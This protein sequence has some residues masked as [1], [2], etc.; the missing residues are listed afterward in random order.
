MK[1]ERNILLSK[2]VT[3][4][5]LNIALLSGIAPVNAQESGEE[6]AE[7]AD[8]VSVRYREESIQDIPA[9]VSVFDRERMDKTGVLNLVDMS[10]YLPNTTF[11]LA[12]GSNATLISFMRGIGQNNTLAGSEQGV[13]VYIDDV[14]MHRPQGSVFDLYDIERVEILRGPQGVLYGRNTAGGVVKLVTKRLADEA[15]LSIKGTLGAY[16]RTDVAVIGSVPFA[17]DTIKLG[18]ALA[19]VS[20][21]GFG[22]N[23]ET[24]EEHF[25]KQALSARVTLELTPLDSLFI[26]LS[27]DQITDESSPRHGHRFITSISDFDEE[28]E[29]YQPFS[30]V[31]DTRAG[32]TQTDHPID[33][34]EYTSTNVSLSI[35]YEINDQLSFKS[36]TAIREYDGE[37]VIDFDNLPGLGL[38]EHGVFENEQLSQDLRLILE[39]DR[40]DATFGLHYL[41]ASAFD[42]FDQVTSFGGR[43]ALS[44][45]TL[46]DVDTTTWAV[47]LDTNIHLTK[48]TVL[49]VGGRFTEDE[50]D[51]H[52]VQAAYFAD[53]SSYF[54]SGDVDSGSANLFDGSRDDSTFT[55]SVSL[56][57]RP[58][59]GSHLVY[60]AYQEGF[61]GGGFDPTANYN[62]GALSSGLA[63]EEVR[64][65]EVGL[66]SDIFDGRVTSNIVVFEN[67]S[68]DAQIAGSIA[69]DTDGDGFADDYAGTKT[70]GGETKMR[71]AE[72]E[73]VAQLTTSLGVDLS[74]GYINAQYTQYAM[75]FGDVSG[76]RSIPNT[77]ARTASLGLRF[78]QEVLSG[79]L[80]LVGAVNYTSKVQHSVDAYYGVDQSGY[81]LINFSATWL[82]DN[83]HWMFGLHGTNL[84]N[85]KY[86]VGGYRVFT[87]GQGAFSAYYGDPRMISASVRYSF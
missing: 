67:K 82:A 83:E 52:I 79:V 37:R 10:A 78:D 6:K 20:R 43:G 70:N 86:I 73:L 71:G 23:K 55:P 2:G 45:F 21:D 11:K 46:E 44:I 32:V 3:F 5:V 42:A 59:G 77:P 80:S 26:R 66:K 1:R 81:S 63:P 36:V 35:H 27:A 8:V 13:G 33:D 68:Q 39:G 15:E 40:F 29:L 48:N 53:V 69:I 75:I 12:N 17:G 62:S 18:G 84:S 61:Q 9:S 58:G 30:N 54:N 50:R 74:L 76:E 57:W 49:A 24:G 87:G 19:Y 31:F 56:S 7:K 28:G 65:L 14:L 4:A 22:E 85:K 34:N 60:G 38:H 51:A 72:L 25:D 16:K 64:G 41:E 47:F